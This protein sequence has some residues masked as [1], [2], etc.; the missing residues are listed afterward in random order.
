[1]VAAE[2]GA[3]IGG[4]ARDEHTPRNVNISPAGSTKV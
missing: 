3:A 2:P 4:G 1:M